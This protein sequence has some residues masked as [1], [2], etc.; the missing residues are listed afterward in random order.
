MGPGRLAA[1]AESWT[2]RAKGESEKA[3]LESSDSQHGSSKYF[4]GKRL[5]SEI[6]FSLIYGR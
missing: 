6:Q 4:S 1:A 5:Q 2:G 3:G